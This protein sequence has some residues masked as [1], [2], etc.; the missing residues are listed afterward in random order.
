MYF[1]YVYTAAA[2]NVEGDC[3]PVS[4]TWADCQY[5]VQAAASM[6]SDRYLEH[7]RMIVLGEYPDLMWNDVVQV[8]VETEM[9][10][11][12]IEP[13]TLVIYQRLYQRPE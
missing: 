10:P 4:I 3:V 13:K 7:L 12:P 11:D 2:R 6:D 5:F 9:D 1:L 8:E